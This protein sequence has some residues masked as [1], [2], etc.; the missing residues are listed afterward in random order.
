MWAVNSGVSLFVITLLFAAIFKILP[1]ARIAWRDVWMGA[2]VT[3][4]LFVAGK[5]LIALYLGRSDPGEAYGA[6]GALAL[7][8]VW[9]YYSSMILFLGAEFTQ[10]WTRRRGATIPPAAGARKVERSE[11]LDPV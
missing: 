7:L 8:L 11:S 4:I 2:F 3:A 10:A 9:V 1:D 6:A 5:F